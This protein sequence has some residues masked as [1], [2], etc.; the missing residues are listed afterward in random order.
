MIYKGI[1]DA[2]N[3]VK[4]RNKKNV[5]L[6]SETTKIYK[7][8]MIVFSKFKLAFFANIKSR[9]SWAYDLNGAYL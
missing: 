8:Y 5:N 1:D 7:Q 6:I 3:Y 2:M 9:I 4:N